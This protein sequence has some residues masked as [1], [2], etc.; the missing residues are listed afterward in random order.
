MQ[1]IFKNC[2]KIVQLKKFFYYNYFLC[3]K[4]KHPVPNSASSTKTTY[5]TT[6]TRIISVYAAFCFNVQQTIS[7]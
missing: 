2:N 1:E 6:C 7:V 4:M 3:A 5:K